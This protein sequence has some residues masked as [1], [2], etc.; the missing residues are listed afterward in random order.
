MFPTDQA[1]AASALPTPA[2]AGTPGFFTGGNPA[3]GT[4]ATVVDPDW[5]NMIQQELINVVEAGGLTPSKTTYNQVLTALQT[6]FA[7]IN[8][9]AT[10]TFSVAP[11]VASNEAVNLGQFATSLAAAGYV[12]IPTASGNLLLQWGP[13][14]STVGDGATFFSYPIAFTSAVYSLLVTGGA[15]AAATTAC[16]LQGDAISLSGAAAYNWGSATIPQGSYLA[17][18]R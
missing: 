16:T 7:S 9:S 10:E 4:P 14:A 5:L 12:K 2:A 15:T 18:G 6:L 1:T 11:G 3:A 13:V 17:I 8:G